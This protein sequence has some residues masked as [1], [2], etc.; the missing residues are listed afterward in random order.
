[1][2]QLELVGQGIKLVIED[3]V[4]AVI[5]EKPLNTAS[6]A[7]HNG[8]GQKQTKAILNVQ[9]SREYGDRHLHEDPEAFIVCSA[10][11]IGLQESFIGMVTAAAVKNYALVSKQDGDLGV[12]VV[13]TA[14][15]DEG[16]TCSHSESA[17]ETI[18]V[19]PIEGTIN[20]IVVI[21]GNPTESCLVSSIITATEAKMA[22]LLELDIRSR[23]SGDEATGTVTDAMVVAKTSR[24]E[25]IVYAGPASKLGQLVGFCTKKAVKEAVMK[26]LECS[27]KRSIQHRLKERHLSVEKLS[28]ELT[29]AKCLGADEKTLDAA[30]NDMLNR[31]SVFAS[32]LLA[33]SELNEEFEKERAPPQFGDGGVLGK[34][35][36]ELLSKQGVDVEKGNMVDCDGVDLP[37]FLKQALVAL[38][39]N[40]VSEKKN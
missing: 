26:G 35:F 20:I 36:G 28:S 1:M 33:A 19:Q 12:S 37:V 14:A 24:G 16:N 25:S 13:A 34:R 32:A 15:D 17:G 4:L 7:F 23:Y 40:R 31:D 9:V 29:K 5:S 30:L 6:S 38:L 18:T 2:R 21:D 8:G 10:K 11:K 3:N 22:A 27:P 39:K